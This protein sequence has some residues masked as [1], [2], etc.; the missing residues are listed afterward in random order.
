MPVGVR[1]NNGS[2]SGTSKL[3][4]LVSHS[5]VLSGRGGPFAQSN[6]ASELLPN[7]VLCQFWLDFH[8]RGRHWEKRGGAL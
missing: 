2:G 1:V 7:P 6:P 8:G 5:Y 4:N 3:D